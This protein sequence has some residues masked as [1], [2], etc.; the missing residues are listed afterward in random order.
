MTVLDDRKLVGDLLRKRIRELGIRQKD[1]IDDKLTTA[2]I[3]NIITGKKNVSKNTISYL[4]KKLN[5]EWEKIPQYVED[6]E[7]KEVDQSKRIRLQLKSI[8]A[9]IGSKYSLEQLKKIPSTDEPYILATM[10]YLQGNF[11]FKKEN[12][13][14]AK[15]HYFQS[16]RIYDSHPDISN[17]NLK[18]AC[19]NGLSRVYFKL[20]QFE[21]A[22]R[23][24]RKGQCYFVECEERKYIQFYLQISEAIYLDNMGLPLEALKVLEI[25]WAYQ[26]DIATSSLLNMYSLQSILYNK[27]KMYEDSI[28]TIDVAI[29]IA[30]QSKSYDHMYEMWTT[31]GVSYKNLGDLDFAT[32]CFNTASSLQDKVRSK[33]LLLQSYHYT[34]KGKL[35]LDE[36][37]VIKASLIL[38]DAVKLSKK[39]HDGPRQS[40]AQ[41]ALGEC[42]LQLDRFS[43]AVEQFEEA[44]KVAQKLS[45][46]EQECNIILKLAQ[47]YENRDIIKYNQ[48]YSLF[49]QLSIKLL[50]GGDR[51]M[52][53]KKA[54]PDPPG[55]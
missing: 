47:C 13:E 16:I 14:K 38:I 48:Y 30:R 20:N 41:T 34:E 54:Q 39:A 51:N 12:W 28:K 36:G 53:Q 1:L 49:Y 18:A 2:T 22:L 11:Y 15:E 50:N 4:C 37:D 3:S 6:Q 46:L 10:S 26:N 52:L 24:T 43:E 27:L 5:W 25:M 45:F 19:F 33:L 17:S 8:E 7:Q 55:D 31:L 23:Y 9:D 21:E 29:E 35:L 32:I 42:Y 40:E 44:R